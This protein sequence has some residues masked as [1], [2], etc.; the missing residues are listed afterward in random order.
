MSLIAR[1]ALIINHMLKEDHI[2]FKLSTILTIYPEAN[3]LTQEG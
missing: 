1:N 2:N 3:I